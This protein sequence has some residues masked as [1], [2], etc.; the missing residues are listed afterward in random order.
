MRRRFQDKAFKGVIWFSIVAL[1][2]Y[3][4]LETVLRVIGRD[5]SA[6]SLGTVN[7]LTISPNEFRRKAAQAEQRILYLKE[8]F[9][10]YADQLLKAYGLSTDPQE[11]AL[12]EIVREKVLDSAG[13]KLNLAVAPASVIEKLQDPR[14]IMQELGPVG[15]LIDKSGSINMQALT[16]YLRRQ[17]MTMQDFENAI[18]EGL[19]RSFLLDIAR[20]AAYV[21]DYMLKQRYIREFVP[22]KYS[23]LTFAAADY[24]P[25]ETP[26]NEALKAFFD[27]QNRKTKRYVI[28]EK[29]AARLVTFN[30]S[31]YGIKISDKEISQYYN[32]HKIDYVDTPEGI[33]V[34]RILFKLEEGGDAA[35]VRSLAEKVHKQILEKPKDFALLAKQHSQDVATA[36]KGGLMGFVSKNQGYDPAFERAVFALKKD[37]DISPL[38][39]T[40]QGIEIIQRVSKRQASYKPLEEVKEGIE[41]KLLTDKFRRLFGQEARKVTQEAA[42]NAQALTA[43]VK[44][45]RGSEKTVDAVQK[46]TGPLS[47]V[48]FK[49]DKGSYGTYFEGDQGIIAQLTEIHPAVTPSLDSVKEQ[50]LHDYQQQHGFEK[51]QQVV[52]TAYKR[53]ATE[54][55]NDLKNAYHAQLETTDFID[56]SDYKALPEL[57]KKGISNEQLRELGTLGSI[58]K[59]ITPEHGYII[60]LDELKKYAPEDYEARKKELLSRAYQELQQRV[61]SGFVA[62]LYK[63]ATIKINK[64]LK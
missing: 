57:S 61:E 19:R 9:G 56:P 14:F 10:P 38:I 25:K 30:P 63:N 27:A 54:P 59:E 4:S 50:V 5:G 42:Q 11:S 13:D 7:G 64:S 37:N 35:K 21:P 46:E 18:E 22:K 8:Q 43:F 24:V 36:K 20:G 49:I 51:M 29:R 33:E 52:D 28:P 44:E 58:S 32:N 17:G 12:Q 39:E 6:Q 60:R 1:I 48:L 62:S 34:R 53:A 55:L 15:A 47:N 45:K 41:Q 16:S 2:I 23:V 26:S 40:A 3:F 31:D